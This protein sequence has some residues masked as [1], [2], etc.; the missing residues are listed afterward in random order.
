MA[1]LARICAQAPDSP[2]LRYADR[3]LTYQ[4]L[5]RSAGSIAAYLE[6]ALAGR[7]EP[8]VGLC[9]GRSERM[10]QAVFGVLAA[11]AGYLPL[12][13]TMPAERLAFIVSDA[14]LAAVIADRDTQSTIAPHVA[15]PVFDV[16]GLLDRPRPVEAP[17]I[18]R[19]A[20]G[21]PPTSSIP[22]G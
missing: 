22:R 12:D 7:D 17:R 1:A 5:S 18:L 19:R 16:D 9:L 6:P 3:S 15:C 11:D 4:A 2:A 21:E 14:R 8:L 10:I 13:P 20:R